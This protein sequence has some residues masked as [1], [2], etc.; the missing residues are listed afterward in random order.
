MLF[1][2]IIKLLITPIYILFD[3]YDHFTN[4]ILYRDKDEFIDSVSK[5]GYVR[6]FYEV[7]KSATQSGVVDR[8]FITGVTPVTLDALTSGFNIL[9]HLSNNL[10]YEAM[11]GFTEQE[12]RDLLRLVLENPDREE[13]V[14]QEM[15]EWYNGYKFHEE[16]QQ[17]IYNSD[18]VLYYLDHFKDYQKA[19][20]TLLDVNIAPDY[21]KLKQMFEVVNFQEN[22]G[23]LQTVLE[24]GYIIAPLITQFSFSR[25]FGS[26][27]LVNFLAYMGNLTMDSMAPGRYKI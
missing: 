9:K 23:V 14:M 2:D 17:T 12:V 18:M 11:M 4:D 5:Q 8:V 27:E 1:L 26:N 25:T 22:K 3:E 15:R 6:K 24:Q 13:E 21:G 20:R 10:T 7:I 19:P 16:S